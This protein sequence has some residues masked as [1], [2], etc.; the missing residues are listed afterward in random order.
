MVNVNLELFYLRNY[1][2]SKGISDEDVEDIVKSAEMEIGI[3]LKNKLNEAIDTAIERGVE[4][5]S[6][7]FINDLVARDDSFLIETSSGGTDYSEPPFHMLDRLLTGAVKPMKDGSGVY[8][9]IPVGAPSL[10]KKSNIYT[11]IFDAQKAISAERYQKSLQDYNNV[12][13]KDSK[14][15]FRTATSKQDRNTQWVIPS[16]EKDFTEELNEINANLSESRDSI[17]L[18]I[19]KEYTERY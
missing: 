9:V 16:K 14:I 8:R 13:P 10:T 5:D 6:S 17:I 19:I 4:K 18:D 2:L 3:A 11:N 1:L 7:D 12:R 15:K